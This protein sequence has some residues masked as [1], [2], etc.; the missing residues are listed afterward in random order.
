MITQVDDATRIRVIRALVGMTSRD[1]AAKMG[2]SCASVTSWEKGRC[3]PQREKRMELATFCQKAGIAF[4]PSG[5][6]VPAGDLLPSQ[7]R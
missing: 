1:F 5:C 3:T 2:V 7:E 6:P 4:M